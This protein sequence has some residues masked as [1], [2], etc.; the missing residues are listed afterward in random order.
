[1]YW[2]TFHF[3]SWHRLLK[4]PILVFVQHSLSSSENLWSNLALP[5]L[6]RL[7]SIPFDNCAV[8]VDVH[9]FVIAWA[10]ISTPLEDTELTG[11]FTSGSGHYV[12]TLSC[13]Y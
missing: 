2:L 1:M 8:C 5:L 3:L 12:W 4:S 6:S 11:D 10:P 9:A 7:L 13:S